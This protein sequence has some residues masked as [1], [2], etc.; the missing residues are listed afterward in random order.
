VPD[1][2]EAAALRTRVEAWTLRTL[3]LTERPRDFGLYPLPYLTCLYRVCGAQAL[4]DWRTPDEMASADS[5]VGG[6]ELQRVL[7]KEQYEW[8]RENE[9][10]LLAARP[11][12]VYRKLEWSGK[13]PDIATMYLAA[14]RMDEAI[15][16]LERTLADRE[17]VLGTEHPSTVDTRDGLASAYLAAGR[18]EEAVT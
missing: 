6:E 7:T 15:T 13:L 4:K 3:L 1:S 14:G 2:Y 18:M 8:F 5:A 12:D 9:T 10:D 17:R 16:L 11:K